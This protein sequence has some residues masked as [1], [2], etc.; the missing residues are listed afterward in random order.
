MS[1]I[2]IDIE[3]LVVEGF[4]RLEAHKIRQ[5]LETELSFLLRHNGM[6]QLEGIDIH[7]D[8]LRL[9]TINIQPG[10]N[11]TRIGQRIAGAIYQQLYQRSAPMPNPATPRGNA[12]SP[13]GN[14]SAQPLI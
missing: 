5:A 13:V 11:V 2:E 3:A 12:P 1:N 6:I 14:Q 8:Q 10:Q 4:S 7:R 9:S